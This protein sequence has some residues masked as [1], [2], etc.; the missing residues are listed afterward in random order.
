MY[1]FDPITSYNTKRLIEI[2]IL[3][4]SILLILLCHLP[5][6]VNFSFDNYPSLKAGFWAPT[7]AYIGLTMF[8]FA[9]GYTLASRYKSLETKEDITRYFKRRITRIYPIWW[10]GLLLE[11][12]IFGI[13]HI[14]PNPYTENFS[15]FMGLM[16]QLIG[17]HG[18]FKADVEVGGGHIDWFIGTILVYY[19]VYAIIAKYARDDI[20]I[21]IISLG[22]YIVCDMYHILDFRF[23][24]YY[25]V[26]LLGIFAGKYNL[27]NITHSYFIRI[28][29][30][31]QGVIYYIAQSSYAVY[32]IHQPLLSVVKYLNNKFGITRPMEVF[33]VFIASL[34]VIMIGYHIQKWVS[35]FNYV[36]S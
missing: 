11:F 21:F 27:L 7:F 13:F 2:D 26:F 15:S 1:K 10:I 19:I 20:D 24:L 16:Y 4:C 8:I 33:I 25:P 17:A 34:I 29:H 28:P 6:F 5:F 3:K 36:P 23:Y 18:F 12:V 35:G 32:V 9:S 14:N 22:I 30:R 31:V